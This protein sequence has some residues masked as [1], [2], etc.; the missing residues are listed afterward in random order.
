MTLR[1]QSDA[2]LEREAVG[3]LSGWLALA[4]LVAYWWFMFRALRS[5]TRSL[6]ELGQWFRDW[7]E[8]TSRS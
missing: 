3:A 1:D 6:A 2:R 5:F 4:A 7:R 8:E